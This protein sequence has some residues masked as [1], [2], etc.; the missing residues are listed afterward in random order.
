MGRPTSIWSVTFNALTCRNFITLVGTGS[1]TQT[2]RRLEMP[3]PGIRQ[4][5]RK[6]EQYLEEPL[7]ERQGRRFTSS[8]P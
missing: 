5:V 6:P 2:A 1:L 4:H 3:Q 7:L 8:L